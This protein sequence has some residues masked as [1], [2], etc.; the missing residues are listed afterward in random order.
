[1]VSWAK[2]TK[3]VDGE[4]MVDADGL[5]TG[6]RG[7]TDGFPCRSHSEHIFVDE[8]SLNMRLQIKHWRIWSV[9]CSKS[10]RLVD[11]SFLSNRSGTRT[12]N[13]KPKYSFTIQWKDQLVM[14]RL[15]KLLHSIYLFETGV[16]YWS[17]LRREEKKTNS[18]RIKRANQKTRL[19]FFD[20]N[21]SF[22]VSPE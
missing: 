16:D 12:D 5:L 22:S 17:R 1:M 2:S 3:S 14:T 6:C 21:V 15:V 11:E 7:G 9:R 4:M 10:M 18:K 13:S 20:A 8:R 19:T